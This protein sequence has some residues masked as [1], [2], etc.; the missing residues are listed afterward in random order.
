M[1]LAGQL[2][3]HNARLHTILEPFRDDATDRFRGL[4]EAIDQLDRLSDAIRRGVMRVRMAPIGPLL[5]RYHRVVR[6]LTR[7]SGKQVRLEIHG[8]KTELDKRMIDELADPLLQIVRNAL[9]H[10]IE[11]PEAR[12]AAGKPPEG[13]LSIQ[14]SHRGNGVL[15]QVRDD[16]AGLNLDRLREKAVEKGVAAAAEAAAMTPTQLQA[17]IWKPGMSTAQKV[18]E[19]SGRGVGLDIVRTNIEFLHGTVEVASTPGQGTTFSIRLPLTLAILRCLMIEFGGETFAIPTELVKEIVGRG[20]NGD[21]PHLP[22]R[23]GG[24]FA[25]MGTVP[26]FPPLGGT[27]VRLRQHVLAT[28][29][30]DEVLCWQ[31][32]CIR[33]APCTGDC[34][35]QSAP[36]T[37]VIVGE[38]GHDVGLMVDRVL[39]QEDVVIKSLAENYRDVP[40][41]AGATILGDGRVALILDVPAL[42]SL[43]LA[44]TQETR[45]QATSS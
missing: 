33:H 4:F 5:N 30:L 40:G 44:R 38:R 12:A 15:I 7:G 37:L 6:D 26:V 28:M 14:A 34:G 21:S 17:L 39:G 41:I 27:V 32:N 43:S 19:V 13:L 3:I 1:G 22:E 42:L 2:T 31:G 23:P 45:K 16:G 9:D 20:E 25:Q 8:E 29:R 10:G 11:L 35:T 18:T 36:N 24:C